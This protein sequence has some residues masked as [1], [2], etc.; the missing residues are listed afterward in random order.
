MKSLITFAKPIHFDGNGYSD[1][2]KAEAL[3]R[4]LDC[5]TSVP[6]IFDA[7]LRPESIEMFKR[8]GVFSKVEI[9]ARNEVKWEIYTKK[10]QIEARVLGD[11]AINHVLPVATRYQSVL[12]DNVS[13]MQAL[14]PKEKFET[15]AASEMQ[16][17]EKIAWH[18]SVIR[19]KAAQMVNARKVA[20]KIECMR[21]KAV[22]YHDTVAPLFD[23][24]RYHIDKLELMIDDEMWTLPKYRELLFIR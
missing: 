8:T 6:V 9:E 4:G 17:I 3:R 20:N 15:L 5:E 16:S 12:L 21:E 7:Y 23:E 14:F 13:K 2:W 18:M 11:L 19:E 24:I 22:A 10:I 1:E